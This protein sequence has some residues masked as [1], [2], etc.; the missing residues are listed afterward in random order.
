M[1]RKKVTTVTEEVEEP[2]YEDIHNKSTEEIVASEKEVKE[3]DGSKDEK[4]VATPVEVKEVKPEFDPDKLKADVAKETTD[5]IVKALT[6]EKETQE[7]K[8]K[9]VAY[10]EEFSKKHGRN[11]TWFEVS[12]FIKDDLRADM[13][14]E[15][16]E[17]Q[18]A[19]EEAKKANQENEKERIKSFNKYIDD[20]LDD[21]YKSK[22]LITPK[23]PK[24]EKDIGVIQRKALFKAMLDVNTER[25]KQGQEPIYSIKEIYYE[26]YEDPT[27]QPAGYDAPV[28]MGKSGTSHDNST[29]EY[30]YAEVHKKPWYSFFKK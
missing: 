17:E 8:D 22:K 29:E 13:K 26:H 15:A 1:A 16:E 11:P 27:K 7:Q 18:K 25:V 6:G 9:Y 5:K 2:K 23:D 21:L 10:S 4:P 19:Q 28:S 30:S 20:Q 24:D 3:D 12:A 14:R